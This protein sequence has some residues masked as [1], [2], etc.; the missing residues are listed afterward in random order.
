MMIRLIALA[1][2]LG[3]LTFF[4]PEPTEAISETQ[5]YRGWNLVAFHSDDCFS[6]D[7]YTHFG[8]TVIAYMDAED[9]EWLLWAPDVPDS[10]T[11]LTHLCPGQVAWFRVNEDIKIPVP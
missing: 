5:V 1:I 4:A 6:L 9:Q 2:V 3:A 7:A 10:L 11:S 8:V